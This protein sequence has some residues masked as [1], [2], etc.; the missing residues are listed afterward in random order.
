MITCTSSQVECK[1]GRTVKNRFLSGT[2]TESSDSES[3]TNNRGTVKLKAIRTR[4]HKKRELAKKKKKEVDKKRTR[5]AKEKNRLAQC[6]T[7]STPTDTPIPASTVGPAADAA[8]GTT[9]SALPGTPAPSSTARQTSAAA[10]G[11]TSTTQTRRLSP[12]RVR[13]YHPR[14]ANRRRKPGAGVLSERRHYQRAGGLLVQKLPFQWFWQ[15]NH[16]QHCI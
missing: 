8:T 13:I 1:S 11:T 3:R 2:G 4:D 9:T 14:R 16:G 10:T 5:V 15:R 6:A 12:G 7:T